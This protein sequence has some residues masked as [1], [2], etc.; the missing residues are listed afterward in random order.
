MEN[1][2][3]WVGGQPRHLHFELILIR[4]GIGADLRSERH[5]LI[6]IRDVKHRDGSAR[7]AG[8]FQFIS[9]PPG[10]DQ[11]I[12]IRHVGVGIRNADRL[13][14]A[15]V[16]FSVLSGEGD[17]V[18]AF[19]RQ[20]R[21]Q[22]QLVS[23]F[24]LAGKCEIAEGGAV[25]RNGDI[26]RGGEDDALQNHFQLRGLGRGGGEVRHVHGL[27]G[28]RCG[29]ERTEE[30]VAVR[31]DECGEVGGVRRELHRERVTRRRLVRSGGRW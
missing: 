25:Q 5:R 30:V 10:E 13:H 20:P 16:V 15:V 19:L 29:N 8:D 28:R 7:E 3:R 31:S 23:A 21:G 9:G 18:V 26:V 12:G 11:P 14:Q 1:W 2:R 24:A 4:G 22:S 17:G 6:G 27:A